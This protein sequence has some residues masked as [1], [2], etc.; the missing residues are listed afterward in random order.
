MLQEGSTVCKTR[1]VHFPLR[2]R[3]LFGLSQHLQEPTQSKQ[4]SNLLTE[5]LFITSTCRRVS[6]STRFQSILLSKLRQTMFSSGK[7]ETLVSID[8]RLWRDNHI[9][10]QHHGTLQKMSNFKL[11]GPFQHGGSFPCFSSSTIYFENPCST[12]D[13]SG[14]SPPFPIRTCFFKDPKKHFIFCISGV[15]F[16]FRSLSPVLIFEEKN[17]PEEL[18]CFLFNSFCQR[19]IGLA[20]Q[21]VHIH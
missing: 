11:Q 5:C 10:G 14:T 6:S 8:V 1:N 12:P 15:R 13:A 20:E 18:K 17:E 2:T 7:S 3:N 9:K 16:Q 19:D 4:V 21:N